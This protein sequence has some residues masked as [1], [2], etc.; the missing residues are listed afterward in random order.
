MGELIMMVLLLRIMKSQGK[1]KVR[2]FWRK[3]EKEDKK[4]R[5]EERSLE[6]SFY[7]QKGIK[8]Y[9]IPNIPLCIP[10]GYYILPS[11]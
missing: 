5:L 9:A 2:V 10:M 7:T 3:E 8:N 11:L 6:A 1:G 4:K